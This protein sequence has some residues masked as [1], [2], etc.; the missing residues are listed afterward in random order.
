M[1]DIPSKPRGEHADAL[2]AGAEDSEGLLQSWFEAVLNT[3]RDAFVCIDR[4]GRIIVFNRAA[5]RIFGY[6]ESEVRGKNVTLLMTKD[7]APAH[8]GY[9]KHYERTGEARAIGQI[10]E[11][12]ARRA[13]GESFP[14]ELS[15]TEIEGANEVR[16]AAFIRD[17]SS[18]R[19]MHRKLVERERLAAIGTTAAKLAHEIGNPLNNMHLNAQLLERRL[20]R[21]GDERALTR[22][23]TVT[24]EIDRLRVLLDD[25]RETARRQQVEY[26][27]LR[28]R[29]FADEL[30]ALIAPAASATG[31]TFELTCTVSEED[32]V[33]IDQAKAKQILVNLCKNALEAMA[34]AGTEHP[35]LRLICALNEKQLRFDVSDNG[36]GVPD[37][38]EVFEP[39]V[40][41]KAHGTGLG[42]AICRQLAKTHGGDLT[43]G[44]SVE[45]GAC[46]TLSLPR[47]P[48]H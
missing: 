7:H 23:K 37:N 19:E 44:S 4:S 46:F 40:T 30:H 22:L 43:V 20:E 25:F 6:A 29:S 48:A 45:A 8:E 21:L 38:V 1:S 36:P 31:V 13:D 12:E 47:V 14:I 24:G 33:R 42:L 10:R 11:V 28:L 17:V 15:V 41:T 3:T 32:T 35:R 16:Y 18:N 26:T 27:T 39:F 5:E 9:V 34:E 2:T